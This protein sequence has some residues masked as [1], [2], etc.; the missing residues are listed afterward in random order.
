M[1]TRA[2]AAHPSDLHILVLATLAVY[3][4]G[5]AEAIADCLDLPVALVETLCDELEAAGRLTITRG[6]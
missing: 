3:G 2:S 1:A 6:C 4:S 5:D